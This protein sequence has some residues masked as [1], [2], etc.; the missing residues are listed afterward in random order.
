[1]TEEQAPPATVWEM[2]LR[3]TSSCSL[4]PLLSVLAL[5]SHYGANPWLASN[6]KML[7]SF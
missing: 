4:L 7:L 6:D 1:M 5:D 3:L 2:F